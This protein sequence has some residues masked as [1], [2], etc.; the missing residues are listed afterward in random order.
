MRCF[1][2]WTLL[3]SHILYACVWSSFLPPPKRNRR[4]LCGLTHSFI[5]ASGRHLELL[6]KV[7]PGAVVFESQPYEPR[8]VVWRALPY[9]AT[10]I[11]ILCR[12]RGIIAYVRDSSHNYR[13]QTA[14]ASGTQVAG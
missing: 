4:L 7:S 12:R 6:S 8:I 13:T 14:V 9:V 11:E 1:A 2:P 5:V 10:A 3:F